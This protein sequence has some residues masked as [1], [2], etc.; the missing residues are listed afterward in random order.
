MTPLFALAGAAH[1]STSN[2]PANQ[3]RLF[4][5]QLSFGFLRSSIADF[6]CRPT[7]EF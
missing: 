5:P 6:G 2:V 4:S 3:T 1:N 7:G